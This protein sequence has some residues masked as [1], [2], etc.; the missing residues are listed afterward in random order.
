MVSRTNLLAFGH[1]F[2][3]FVPLSFCYFK[4]KL[5]LMI[6]LFVLITVTNRHFLLNFASWCSITSPG[7]FQLRIV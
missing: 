5:T 7:R 1:L 3:T 2:F 4:K 6:W